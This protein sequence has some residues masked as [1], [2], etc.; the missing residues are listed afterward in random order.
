VNKQRE[1]F[2]LIEMVVVIIVV[3]ILASLA[4]PRYRKTVERAKNKGA[5]SSL[6]LISAAE[7]INYYEIGAYVSCTS[8]SDCNSKLRLSLS[9][10]DWD[11]SVAA[12][13]DNFTATAQR[14]GGVRKWTLTFDGT[15]ETLT[16][17]GSNVYCE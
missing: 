10:K 7:R 1:G 8:A 3:A 9:D 14:Q 17:S 13:S 15:S 5:K 16:C 2:T 6:E 11:Y 12:T 4:L